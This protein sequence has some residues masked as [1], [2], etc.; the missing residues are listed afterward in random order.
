[1]DGGGRFA[2][3]LNSSG[4]PRLPAGVAAERRR[5]ALNRLPNNVHSSSAPRA[6]DVGAFERRL[7]DW[8]AAIEALHLPRGIGVAA[9]AFIIL[10]SIAYGAVRGDHVPGAV[11]SFNEIRD[12]IGN[13]VGMHI[14][15]VALSGQKRLS[16][17]DIL[18]SAGVTD[19]T[20]LLFFDVGAA[21]AR[22]ESNPWIATATVQKLYPDRLQIAVI[23]REAFALWQQNG[24]VFVISDDGTVLE[25]YMAQHFTNLPLIVGQG[26]QL[27][28]KDFLALLA[29][30]PEIRNDVR[31]SVLVA[32][33]R[34]N[35]RLRSGIDVRLPEADVEQALAQF[36]ALNRSDKLT[37]RDI[38]AVDLRTPGRVI[39]Q[40][41]DAAALAREEALKAKKAKAKGGSE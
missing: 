6:S 1:M 19:D 5:R 30:Y 25:P 27:R 38:V 21:R 2:Q 3:S 9:S 18:A 29:R 15:T 39:V 7:N 4:A 40:L 37:S 35:L 14:A 34:W 28:A 31:A 11:A 24:R 26:A 16:R 20:A 33:R 13:A 32:E 17:D 41:S 22:L 23:E 36:M 10:A 12:T 8:A